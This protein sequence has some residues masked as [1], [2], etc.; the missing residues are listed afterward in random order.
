MMTRYGDPSSMSDEETEMVR[1]V[2][3]LLAKVDRKAAMDEFMRGMEY[4]DIDPRKFLKLLN[5][6]GVTDHLFSSDLGGILDM[7]M[8]SGLREIG[9]RHAPI[10]WMMKN[11]PEEIIVRKLDGVRPEDVKKIVVLVKTLGLSPEVDANT[12]GEIT[13][14]IMTSGVPARKIR[15]WLTKVG[16]KPD[17][18]TDAFIT[19]LNSPRVEPINS[20]GEV[21]DAFVSLKNP[22]S[23]QLRT[24][25]AN[26]K[27][28]E[29]ELQMFRSLMRKSLKPTIPPLKTAELPPY[30][31]NDG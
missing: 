13:D 8:P 25:D 19:Y 12:L 27:K 14:A 20:N 17:S 15:A 5:V 21:T 24:E 31:Q 3:P 2:A 10:A 30:E 16:G 18:L 29:M 1:K 6:L 26:K 11:L 28:R 9:D 4:D 22:F 7:E 23:G